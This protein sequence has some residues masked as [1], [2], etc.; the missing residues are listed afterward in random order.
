VISAY[1][2]QESILQYARPLGVEGVPLREALHRYLA[3]PVFAPIDH[4]PFDNAAMD[5]FA[6]CSGDTQSVSETS[7][8]SLKVIG[9]IAA[10]GDVGAIHEL[11]LRTGHTYRI[12]TGAPVPP[13]ADA[14][15]PFEETSF[16]ENTCFVTK[17]IS[18]EANIR[19]AGEDVRKGDQVLEAGERITPR[20]IALLAALGIDRLPVFRR[21]CIRIISTGSELVEPGLPLPQGRIYNSNGPALEAAL[22]ELGIYP[23]AF[24][25]VSDS[26]EDLRREIRKNLDG[27]VLVTV[28]GVSAGDYDLIPKVLRELGAKIIFHKVSIKPGKPLLFA[29]FENK[30]VFSLPGNPVSALVVFDRFVRPALLKM[31]G[32]K[33]PLRPRRIAIAETELRGTKGK[34]DYLRGVVEYREGNYFARS[35]GVQGSAH[36]LPLARSNAVL[37]IPA[38]KELIQHLEPLEVEILEE[39]S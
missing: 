10:G 35:A 3:R 38:E 8:V 34:E 18:P 5:G 1:E 16:N 11:P 23:E 14:V 27:D 37:I 13:G 20:T 21:P 29:T 2:A 12:M 7:P 24:T 26:E 33:N 39:E 36:L 28:G 19:R 25:L 4:P 17:P 30:L 31:V 32:S 15:I 6:V 22:Q 9:T